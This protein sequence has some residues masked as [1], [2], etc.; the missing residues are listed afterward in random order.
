MKK[1]MAEE[2]TGTKR[3]LIEAAGEL[4][5]LNGPEA[6]SVRAIAEKARA[7]IAAINY[8]FGSKDNLYKEVLRFVLVENAEMRPGPILESVRADATPEEM[9]QTIRT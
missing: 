6:T 3:A 1:P 7:N 2:L 9:A 4:F 8:H 5:A